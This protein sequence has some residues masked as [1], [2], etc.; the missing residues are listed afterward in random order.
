LSTVDTLPACPIPLRKVSALDHE[1]INDSMDGRAFVVQR[2][3]RRW[4]YA[5][6]AG[7]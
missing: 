2:Y 1:P 3:R 6:F 4:R 5:L 7:T